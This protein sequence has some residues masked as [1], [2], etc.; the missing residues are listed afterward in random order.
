MSLDDLT[1][2]GG[3]V[4]RRRDERLEM[5]IVRARPAPHD[6]VLPKGHIEPGETPK[7]CAR[8]EIREEA[9]VDGELEVLIGVDRYMGPRGAI[10]V[11]FYLLQYVADVTPE[12]TRETRWVTFDEATNLILFDRLRVLILDAQARLT[13]TARLP[14]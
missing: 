1:H 6:W 14:S 9:G 10:A 2:A 3:I 13:S 8:R 7:A 5:L 12:E 4:Y 11:A